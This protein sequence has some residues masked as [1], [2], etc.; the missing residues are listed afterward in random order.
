MSSQYIGKH[1]NTY[2]KP[3]LMISLNMYVRL[4]IMLN[5]M[6]IT[7][8]T[9]PREKEIPMINLSQEAEDEVVTDPA[10]LGSS[11]PPS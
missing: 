9:M 1:S 6:T 10:W 7:K 2:L 5:R 8:K 11:G 4:S 3:S